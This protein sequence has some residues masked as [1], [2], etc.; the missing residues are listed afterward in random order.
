MTAKSTPDAP[1]DPDLLDAMLRSAAPA[2]LTDAVAARLRERVLAVARPDPGRDYV[3]VAADGGQWRP[4]LPGVEVKVLHESRTHRVA[5]YRLH[6]GGRLP[7][8][9][10]GTEEDCIVLEGE[11]FVD[12]IALRKGGFHYARAGSVHHAI[13]TVTGALL[14]IRH[15][16]ELTR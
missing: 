3:S 2:P 8:H 15:P 7:P 5:L 14:Y 13:T 16:I 1:L 10:H 9:A 6:P 12:D 4:F 11:A